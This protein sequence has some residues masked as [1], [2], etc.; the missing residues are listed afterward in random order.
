ML[1]GINNVSETYFEQSPDIAVAGPNV[2]GKSPKT[3]ITT[4]NSMKQISEQP[5]G[6]P[7][8]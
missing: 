6:F 1:Y 3:L 7:A 5:F 4:S 2:G 8:P